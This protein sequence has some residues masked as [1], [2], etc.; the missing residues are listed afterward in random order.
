M[1]G[2]T[3]IACL[4]SGGGYLTKLGEVEVGRARRTFTVG[5]ETAKSCFISEPYVP[6]AADLSGDFMMEYVCNPDGTASGR[7]RYATN[8]VPPNE[9]FPEAPL[10]LAAME[11][12]AAAEHQRNFDKML[13][14]A[15]NYGGKM[16]NYEDWLKRQ[17]EAMCKPPKS[18]DDATDVKIYMG[19]RSGGK[20][21]DMQAFADEARK[22]LCDPYAAVKLAYEMHGAD[23]IE[24]NFPGDGGWSA[25]PAACKITWDGKPEWYRVKRAKLAFDDH[26]HNTGNS[27]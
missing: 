23:G 10:N 13:R 14:H 11:M 2:L 1:D 18:L 12:A 26:T 4:P 19:A 20:Q 5:T 25:W 3:R 17:D 24:V 6:V 22:A 9:P 8:F 16:P 27:P 21:F 15:Q 7:M